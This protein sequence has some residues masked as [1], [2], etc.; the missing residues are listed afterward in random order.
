MNNANTTTA[1]TAA[2][3]LGITDE[4]N[5]CECCG[6]TDLK[7]TVVLDL[8]GAVA[9]FGSECAARR[10]GRRR[11]QDVEKQARQA[12]AATDK[13][14]EER[15]FWAGFLA[16][17]GRVMNA[18]R[19]HIGGLPFPAFVAQLQQHAAAAQ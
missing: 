7:S 12:Q 2:K 11:K 4:V 13:R 15:A 10:L 14:A 1:P 5:T 16:D 9:H 17:D 18:F 8:D 6:R 19:T 3:I